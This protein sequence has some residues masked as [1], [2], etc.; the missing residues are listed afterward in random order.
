MFMKWQEGRQKTGYLKLKLV[1]FKNVD[2]Y[3]LKYP[4]GSYIPP[5]T[6]P[7]EGKRHYRLNIVLWGKMFFEPRVRFFRPDVEMH[8]VPEVWK[9]RYV[10]SAGWS[11]G[12]LADS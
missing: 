5:H 1:G 3:I 10:F 4:V 12:S 8:S 2:A 7:V 11:S 9:T 6:D